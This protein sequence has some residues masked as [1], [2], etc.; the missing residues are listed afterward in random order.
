MKHKRTLHLSH[1]FRSLHASIKRTH[2]FHTFL[3]LLRMKFHTTHICRH[4]SSTHIICLI[5]SYFFSPCKLFPRKSQSTVDLWVIYL[6]ARERP[7]KYKF[8][9]TSSSILLYICIATKI[10]NYLFLLFLTSSVE[11]FISLS[12]LSSLSS[13]NL[14][15]LIRSR[16]TVSSFIKKF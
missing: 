2:L 10:K 12:S 4:F 16:F 13:L 15:S 9:L 11:Y 14:K 7:T 3:A 8:C 1:G 5:C 6:R